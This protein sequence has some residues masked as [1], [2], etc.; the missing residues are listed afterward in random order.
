[1]KNVLQKISEFLDELSGLDDMASVKINNESSV[2]LRVGCTTEY[3]CMTVAQFAEFVETGREPA[4]LDWNAQAR[5]RDRFK[6]AA[7]ER[8]K[9]RIAKREQP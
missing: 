2:F 7:I 8:L 3:P 6:K 1:M 5:E 9:E 4:G